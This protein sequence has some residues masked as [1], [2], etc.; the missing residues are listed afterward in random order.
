V[1][2]VATAFSKPQRFSTGVFDPSGTETT[3]VGL[4]VLSTFLLLLVGM[5]VASV[6]DRFVRRYASARRRR[7]S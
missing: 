3:D 5:S 4:L 2:A 7:E 1:R 6:R